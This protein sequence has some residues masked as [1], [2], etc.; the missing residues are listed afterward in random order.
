MAQVGGAPARS[1]DDLTLVEI[2][3]FG[4]QP[5]D[6]GAEQ[7]ILGEGSIATSR[8]RHIRAG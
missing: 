4:D 8:A 2:R 3:S 7:D 5:V 1:G 6:D